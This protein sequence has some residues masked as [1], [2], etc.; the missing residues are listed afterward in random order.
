[1]RRTRWVQL[2]I[3]TLS[4]GGLLLLFLAVSA[5]SATVRG[6]VLAGTAP[7]AGARVRVRATE[8]LT[9]SDETGAFF[10]QGLNPGQ[11][12]EVTAWYTGY[13]IASTKVVPPASDVIL[14]LRPYH[15]EDHPDYTW[16]DPISGTM[17]GACGACHP[18][19]VSQW[20]S[21]AHGTAVS[22]ARFFSLYNGTDISGTHPVTPGYLDDFPGTAGNCASCH[23]PGAAVDHYM[24]TDM[25]AV[26]DMVTAGIHCDFCHKV[27]GAYLDATTGSVYPNAPGV[28][29]L[30]VLRPPAGDNIFFGP[31]DD[32]HDPDTYLPLMSE[33]QFCAPCHQFSFWGTPIYESYDEWLRSPYAA[34]GVT[35]QNCHMPPTGDE[36]FALPEVG[37]LPHPPAQIPSHLQRGALDVALL[38]DTVELSLTATQEGGE[39]L[40]SATITNSGAGHH[41][42]TDHPGRHLLLIVTAADEEGQALVQNAGSTIPGWGGPE[43][44]LPGTAFAKILQDAR[45]GEMPVVSY[46]KQSFIVSDNRIPALA[47]DESQVRFRLPATAGTVTIQAELRMRRLFYD[48]ALAKGWE[49][50]DITMETATVTLEPHPVST[51]H[52]P[53]LVGASAD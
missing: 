31:Y 53:L 18:M 45:S 27:G 20:I 37:G 16:T 28:Q 17:P 52:L 43:A 46:W 49:A 35:C 1:M 50:A 6:V 24:A 12:I 4:S 42:P 23:A 19:I 14:T 2:L 32:I 11:E 48:L 44:G 41:V 26:R 36:Y 25:N 30:R 34:E 9:F 39:I 38:Q 47:S 29:S 13:Y 10:L 3:L 40:V 8:N 5:S 15:T 7:V 21:N 51:I 22:N 33:S